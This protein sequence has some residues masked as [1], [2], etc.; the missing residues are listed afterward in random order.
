MWATCGE[1]A[2]YHCR[3]RAAKKSSKIA[4]YKVLSDG[5]GC[6]RFGKLHKG[7]IQLIRELCTCPLEALPN[8]SGKLL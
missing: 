8:L 6:L 7:R 3:S 2:Q 4:S 5:F 1:A